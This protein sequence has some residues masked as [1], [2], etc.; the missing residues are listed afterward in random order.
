MAKRYQ[1]NSRGECLRELRAMRNLHHASLPGIL[2]VIH[3]EDAEWLVME[4]VPGRCLHEIPGESF[5]YEQF[6]AIAEQLAE[7]LVYLHNR[8]PPVLHLDIKPGNLIWSTRG[9]LVLLDFG[10]AVMHT[11][12]D[13]RNP[14]LGTPGFAA[15]EQCIQNIALDCRADIYGFGALLNWYLLNMPEYRQGFMLWEYF[16]RKE[17][18]SIIQKSMQNNRNDRYSD[19]RTVLRVIR[20]KRWKL[21]MIRRLRGMIAAGVLLVSIVIF[22]G[23]TLSEEVKQKYQKEQSSCIELLQQSEFLGFSAAADY[24]RRAAGLFPGQIQ[25]WLHLLDRIDN[26]AVFDQQ[27]EYLLKEIL[28]QFVPRENKSA[29]AVLRNQEKYRYAAFRTGMSY[30]YY[31]AG[32]GGKNA[33]VRWFEKALDVSDGGMHAEEWETIAQLHI[34]IQKYYENQA[35]D[36][37]TPEQYS[38]YWSDLKLLWNMKTFAEESEEIRVQTAK[39]LISGIVMHSAELVRNGINKHEMETVINGV[40][41]FSE[42]KDGTDDMKLL[43]KEAEE[44]LDRVFLDN[45]SEEDEV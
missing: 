14:C 27:E 38:Q 28:F 4:Y 16:C 32:S 41:A 42:R 39:E 2:D 23:I 10:A 9:K 36:E 35:I 30:W 1:T 22:A 34:R 5:S 15:P 21:Q 25:W 40:K 13:E 8:T 11:Q 6:W 19:S 43:A 20:K 44:T 7:V 12:Q 18:R 29:E 45:E 3:G 17:I 33:A 24:Y 26:D 31:Y 37:K